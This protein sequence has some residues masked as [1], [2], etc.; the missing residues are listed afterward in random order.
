MIGG[1]TRLRNDYGSQLIGTVA[2]DSR[3]NIYG[4]TPI[5]SYISQFDP[6]LRTVTQREGQFNAKEPWEAAWSWPFTATIA[7]GWRTP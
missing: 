2:V 7:C 6:E 5:V 4:V 3:G 1:G